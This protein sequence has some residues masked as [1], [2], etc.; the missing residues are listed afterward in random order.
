MSETVVYDNR[1]RD[2]RSW[3][4]LIKGD[5]FVRDNST[6]LNLYR[7]LKFTSWQDQIREYLC[8]RASDGEEVSFKVEDVR[9]QFVNVVKVT[10]C[11]EDID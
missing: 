1:K 7:Y 3:S 9:G 10:I 8:I 4:N 2:K 5:W 6:D 11:I